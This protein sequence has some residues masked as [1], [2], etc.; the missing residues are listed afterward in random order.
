MGRQAL[1]R[2]G[3][4]RVGSL[5]LTQIEVDELTAQYGTVAA[6]LRVAVDGLLAQKS[7]GR[8]K[9]RPTKAQRTSARPVEAARDP[10]TAGQEAKTG[11]GEV[12][13]GPI[14]PPARCRIHREYKVVRRWVENGVQYTEKR[15][16][17]CGHL[18]T[19][20]DRG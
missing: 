17:A 15:C 11:S 12:E 5:R 20:V 18:S 14:D 7:V 1:G 3:R 8:A 9:K 4:T 16:G 19:G 10:E 13:T 2:H 6:A